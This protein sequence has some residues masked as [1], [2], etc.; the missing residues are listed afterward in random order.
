MLK[1]YF[2]ETIKHYRKEY[3]P[4]AGGAA[5]IMLIY[6]D[7]LKGY[8]SEVSSEEILGLYGGNPAQEMKRFL[9]PIDT[10][11]N[12][13]DIL[14]DASGERWGVEKIIKASFSRTGNSH[15]E[16]VGVKYGGS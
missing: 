9:F 8:T 5:E 10:G 2:T 16:V 14:E 15:L 6:I 12:H 11:I 1:D 7:D 3:Q 4:D 13:E